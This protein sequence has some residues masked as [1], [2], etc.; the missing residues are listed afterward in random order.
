MITLVTTKALNCPLLHV[1]RVNV[2]DE[3]TE[4]NPEVSLCVEERESLWVGGG[5]GG[6]VLLLCNWP[7]LVLV[8]VMRLLLL[9][10]LPGGPPEGC[11][12][13]EEVCTI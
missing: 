2:H 3:D 1:C 8:L 6:D 10:P 5:G 7:V 4:Y 12:A 11:G 9:F 13:S